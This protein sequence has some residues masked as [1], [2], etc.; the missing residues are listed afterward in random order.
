MAKVMVSSKKLRKSR[1]VFMTVGQFTPCAEKVLTTAYDVPK[2][3]SFCLF[4][5]Q[6]QLK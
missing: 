4:F 5:G 1:T 6:D 2:E 3:V